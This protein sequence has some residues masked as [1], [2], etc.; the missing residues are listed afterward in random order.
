VSLAPPLLPDAGAVVVL[1]L[2][3]LLLG[4]QAA[5]QIVVTVVSKTKQSDE[6]NLL[7]MVA[8]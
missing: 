6:K 3:T 8:M 5:I 4:W 1:L 2:V 7:V